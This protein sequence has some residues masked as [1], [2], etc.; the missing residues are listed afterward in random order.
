M[1]SI[2]FLLQVNPQETTP[3]RFKG[4]LLVRLVNCFKRLDSRKS[5]DDLPSYFLRLARTHHSRTS[6]T[7]LIYRPIS[8]LC[9]QARIL[10][11]LI[12]TQVKKYGL[13]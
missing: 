10:E 13:F 6:V 5:A 9:I 2:Q 1:F 7:S 11:N 12:N 8:K 3:S 4:S